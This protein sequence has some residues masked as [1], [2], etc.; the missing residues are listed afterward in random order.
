MMKSAQKDGYEVAAQEDRCAPRTRVAIA[1]AMR[2]AGSK[3][4]QT[5]VRDIS[6]SG[7]SAIA[8]SRLAPGTVCWLTLPGRDPMKAQVVWWEQGR[9]GFAFDCLLE[10]DVLNA[11]VASDV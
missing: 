11:I 9:A 4:L 3:R 1:A 5:V 10:Q 6:L 8:L 7:F 2:P